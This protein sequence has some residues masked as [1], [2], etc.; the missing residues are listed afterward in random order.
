MADRISVRDAVH[1]LHLAGLVHGLD[2]LGVLDALATPSTAAEVAVACH[3]DP[4][5]LRTCLAYLAGTSDVIARDGDRFVVTPAWDGYARAYVRQYVGAYGPLT[6]DLTTVLRHPGAGAGL[7]DRTEQARGYAAGRTVAPLVAQLVD[8]LALVPVLDVGCGPGAL[9]VEL[10]SRHPGEEPLGWGVDASEEMCAAARA[11]LAAHGLVAR[12]TIVQGDALAP[13]GPGRIAGDGGIPPG[14]VRSIVAA[15]L[16][17][18]LWGP[19]RGWPA[20]A[21]WLR[22]VAGTFPGRAL[23]VADYFG[24]L[25]HTD[26][27]WPAQTALHDLVQALSGQGIPP[28][29]RHPWVAAYR[30]AGADLLHMVED[31]EGSFFIHVVRLPGDPPPVGPGRAAGP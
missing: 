31:E 20:V 7:V 14:E 6:H 4:D 21:A 8:Q 30:D 23:V 9:L 10:G 5:L 11:R 25:G 28:A 27:P 16:L 17:N 3:V 18:E 29:D 1:G 24:R 26:P 12:A 22:D 15:S 2:A 19:G 13:G